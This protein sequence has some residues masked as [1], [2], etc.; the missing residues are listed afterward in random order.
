[1]SEELKINLRQL[2]NAWIID[3]IG[4]VT[5]AA[6]GALDQAYQHITQANAQ[7]LIINFAGSDYVASNGLSLIAGMLIQARRDQVQVRLAGLTPHLQKLC[8]MMGLMHYAEI[9]AN[10][11]EALQPDEPIP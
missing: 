7:N 8:K 10:I 4:D 11:Q 5:A 3:L 1:M 6:Q 2:G 9:C